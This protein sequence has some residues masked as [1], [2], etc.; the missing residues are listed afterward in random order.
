MV[1][2][3]HA[4]KSSEHASGSAGP[5]LAAHAPTRSGTSNKA[6][7]VLFLGSENSTSLSTPAWFKLMF[8]RRA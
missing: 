6:Q 8:A 3:V 4:F 2:M 5:S 1:S 7:S